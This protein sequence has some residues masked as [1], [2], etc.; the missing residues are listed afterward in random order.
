ML[1]QFTIAAGVALLFEAL[2]RRVVRRIDNYM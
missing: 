1:K 2:R